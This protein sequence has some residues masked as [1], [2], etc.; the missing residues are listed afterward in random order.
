LAIHPHSALPLDNH[1]S[2]VDLVDSATLLQ[3]HHHGI[4][5]VTFSTMLRQRRA[6]IKGCYVDLIK[7]AELLGERGCLRKSNGGERA[8]V[9]L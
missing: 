6:W 2:I 8:F 5:A 4:E 9:L 1:L 3:V 7:E